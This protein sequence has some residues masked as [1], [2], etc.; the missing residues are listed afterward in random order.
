VQN[1]QV[2]QF[3]KQRDALYKDMSTSQ[4]QAAKNQWLERLD[5]GMRIDQTALNQINVELKK[6]GEI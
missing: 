6:R 2:L 4:L 5:S 1:Y 3:R